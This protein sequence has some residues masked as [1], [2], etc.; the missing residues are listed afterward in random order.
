[1]S[2]LFISRVSVKWT[3]IVLKTRPAR[4]TTV[5]THANRTLAE[6]LISVELLGTSQS[7]ASTKL[8]WNQS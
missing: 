3:M 8:N 2:F 4:I 1:M 7:V 5:S 6:R